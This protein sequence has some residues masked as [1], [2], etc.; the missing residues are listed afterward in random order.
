MKERLAKAVNGINNF[1]QSDWMLALDALLIVLGWS[2]K[3]WA[4]FLPIMVTLNILP[5]FIAKDTKHLLPMLMMFSIIISDPMHSLAVYSPLLVLL[6]VLLGGM[7]FNLIYFKRSFVALEPRRIKGFGCTLMALVVPFALGGVGSTS[8]HPLAVL[9]ALALVLLFDVG[10]IFLFIT[11]AESNRKK[12]LPEYLLK[13][14][15]MMGAIITLQIIAYLGSYDGDVKSAILSGNIDLGWAVSNNAAPILAMCI[16]ATLY[17]CI[18]KSKTCPLFAVLALAEYVLLFTTGSSGVILFATIAI[19]AFAIYVIAKTQNKIAFGITATL[20]V[21]VGAI[22]L[23]IFA[24]D[25]TDVLTSVL[26]RGIFPTGARTLYSQAI[27]TFK[28]WPI[29]GAGWDFRLG[30][31]AGDSYSPFWYNSTVLQIMACMG[32]VGLVTFLFFYF[33]RY[34]TLVSMRKSPAVLALLCGSLI[35]DLYGMFDMNFFSP[36]FFIMTLAMTL[37]AE[38]NLPENKC[39]AFGG[40]DPFRVLVN[41]L[42]RASV[43]IKVRVRNRHSGVVGYSRVDVADDRSADEQVPKTQESQS[44]AEA[45]SEPQGTVE[46]DREAQSPANEIALKPDDHDKS[47]RANSRVHVQISEELKAEVSGNRSDAIQIEQINRAVKLP[48]FNENEH[49]EHSGA[50][51]SAVQSERD[52]KAVSDIKRNSSAKEK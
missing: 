35:F 14:L 26:Q 29:F 13:T 50:V 19:C 11:G 47:R 25:A 28:K 48:D 36:P 39:R 22:L 3:L 16:P 20:A 17:F 5:L 23:F 2:L 51:T 15:A 18:K 40:H 12:E 8:E 43:S 52:D 24:E 10:Y 46:S 27:E 33:W 37:A 9:A 4:I 32:A 38:V 31:G 21:A 44:P 49:E 45:D 7:I 41:L 1:V 34:R 30:E 42:K 6:I